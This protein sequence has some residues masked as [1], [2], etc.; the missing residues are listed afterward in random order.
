[1]RISDWS[2]DV[3][4]SDLLVTAALASVQFRRIAR[5]SDRPSSCRTIAVIGP[6]EVNTSA[7]FERP[8]VAGSCCAA[9]SQRAQKAGQLSGYSASCPP[10]IQRRAEENTSEL[11][12]LMRTSYA[13]F[14]L[15]KKKNHIHS[16]SADS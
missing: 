12:S 2:S 1:M 4:S 15:K 9:P 7:V 3:C 13:V 6:P 5:S 16:L 8:S 11:Q 14:C 10:P